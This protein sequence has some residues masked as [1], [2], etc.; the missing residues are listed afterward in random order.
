MHHAHTETDEDPHSPVKL[1]LRKVLLE[2]VEV[3]RLSHTEEV[4]ARYGHGTPDDWLERRVYSDRGNASV[5]VML[6]IDI[7][8]FGPI[9][10]TIWAVQMAWIPFFAAGVI[11]GVCHHTG[12][13]NFE[14]PDASDELRALGHS[15]RR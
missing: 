6:T 8:L 5:V 7:L 12:Y 2:G 10:L 15:H 14:T 3:Y 13:R 4:M 9:G 1:G 11:N